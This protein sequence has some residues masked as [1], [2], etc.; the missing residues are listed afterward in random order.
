MSDDDLYKKLT[1]PF[2]GYYTAEGVFGPF[3]S[4]EQV[5]SRLNHVLGVG[6]WSFNVIQYALVPEADEIVALGELRAII[7]GEWVSRQQFGGQK[8]KRV[9]ATGMPSNLAD[10]HK[11]AATD[12]LKK[13]ASLLGVGLYLMVSSA[14]WHQ[15]VPPQ[16]QANEDKRTARPAASRANGSPS[17]QAAAPDGQAA[18]QTAPAQAPVSTATTA[19]RPV[20]CMNCQNELGPVEFPPKDGKPG[21]TWTVQQLRAHG[22]KRF[23]STLCFPCFKQGVEYERNTGKRA[24]G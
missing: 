22:E 4:G 24:T 10:D 3:L 23:S 2:E 12:A 8:I 16:T 9:K 17:R 15:G 19:A 6:Q 1:A 13:C 20:K 11:G 5:A 21:E 7:D 14:T 18:R